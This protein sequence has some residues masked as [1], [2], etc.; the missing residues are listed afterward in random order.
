MQGKGLMRE[1]KNRREFS[2]TRRRQCGGQNGEAKDRQ[3]EARTQPPVNLRPGEASPLSVGARQAE[4]CFLLVLWS[5]WGEDG[6]PGHLPLSGRAPPH[7]SPHPRPFFLALHSCSFFHL[8]LPRPLSFSRNL[9]LLSS[10]SPS[11]FSLPLLDFIF[12]AVHSSLFHFL[13]PHQLSFSPNLYFLHFCSSCFLKS[14]L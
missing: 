4:N 12:A 11:P 8:L 9:Y 13:F 3:A 14:F 10:S 7:S 2:A 6:S 1:R 5:R